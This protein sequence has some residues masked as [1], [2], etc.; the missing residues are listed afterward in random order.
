[1]HNGAMRNHSKLALALAGA[2]FSVS[3]VACDDG[4]ADAEASAKQLAAALTV[5]DVG[6]IA[7][8]GK[9]AAAADARL[10]DVFKALEPATPSVT[11]GEMQLESGTAVVPLTYQW[12]IGSAEW[13]YTVSAELKKSGDTWQPVWT[14]ALLA[15]DLAEDEVIGTATEAPPRADI[16]GAGD[17]PLVTSRPVVHVGID[18]VL[19]GAADPAA[20][21]AAL[22]RLAGVDPGA[23]TQQVQAAGAEA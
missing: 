14:P 19:L 8:E 10:K 17:V 11:A 6:A 2:V 7:F 22:A 23:Y 15:P 9:D 12:S 3:L 16:L 13:R 21:A 4:R 18:K 1:M 5:L 20:A